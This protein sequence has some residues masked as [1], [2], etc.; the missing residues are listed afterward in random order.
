ML[1]YFEYLYNFYLYLYDI[2]YLLILDSLQKEVI[3]LE[4]EVISLVQSDLDIVFYSVHEEEMLY[5]ALVNEE[6]EVF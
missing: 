2:V 3:S 6:L 1:Y 5:G 4:I